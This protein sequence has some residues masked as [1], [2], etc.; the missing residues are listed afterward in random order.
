MPA[1]AASYMRHRTGAFSL[2]CSPCPRTRT[3]YPGPFSHKRS[4]SLRYNGLHPLPCNSR[5]G[6]ITRI[7]T[8][9][10]TSEGWKAELVYSLMAVYPDSGYL[11][12]RSKWRT[13]TILWCITIHMCGLLDLQGP[14]RREDL[15][16]GATRW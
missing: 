7:T 4:P 15:C 11:S 2:Y 12:T 10:S 9:F 16:S 1:A 5:M 3:L 8:Y 13:R 14:N 6:P